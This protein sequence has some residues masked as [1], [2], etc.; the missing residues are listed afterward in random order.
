MLEKMWKK[1][2]LIHCW[3]ECTPVWP[4]R[5]QWKFPQKIKDKPDSDGAHL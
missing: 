1:R 3:W 4:S 5:D 2:N